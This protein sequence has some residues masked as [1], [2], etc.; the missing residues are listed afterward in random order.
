MRPNDPLA[1][2][3]EAGTAFCSAKSLTHLKTIGKYRSRRWCP[4]PVSNPVG[5]PAKHRRRH[6][7]DKNH[8]QGIAGGFGGLS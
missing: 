8:R 1:Q 2:G 6:Q 5:T 3:S 7:N 4:E